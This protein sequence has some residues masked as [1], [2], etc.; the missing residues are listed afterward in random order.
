[1]SKPAFS[2]GDLQQGAKSLNNAPEIRKKASAKG[3]DDGEETIARLT[4]L[5]ERCDGDLDRIF[6]E[7][8][9]NPTKAKKPHNRPKSAQEFATKFY[10]GFYD[11]VDDEDAADSKSS[12]K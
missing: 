11:L 8:N 4:D 1:M 3:D 12:H 7:L 2:L 6:E 10:Q 9:A 5:Y